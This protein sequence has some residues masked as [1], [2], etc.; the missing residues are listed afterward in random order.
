M[1]RKCWKFLHS[2]SLDRES[3]V[4]SSPGHAFQPIFRSLLTVLCVLQSCSSVLLLCDLV[5]DLLLLLIFLLTMSLCLTKLKVTS[6]FSVWLLIL[7]YLLGRISGIP[8]GR[9]LIPSFW[10]D[11]Y[12]FSGIG[13]L[14]INDFYCCLVR[15]FVHW[16]TLDC[17]TQAVPFEAFCIFDIICSFS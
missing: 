9:Y 14:C 17:T 11:F 5:E 4:F 6:W 13:H 1:E 8:E 2:I 15:R 16:E 7:D 3:V 10:E 12:W